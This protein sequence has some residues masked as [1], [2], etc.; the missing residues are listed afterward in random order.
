MTRV[1]CSWNRANR[2]FAHQK[3]SDSHKNQRANSQLCLFIFAD[4]DGLASGIRGTLTTWTLLL[5]ALAGRVIIA[6]VR[7]QTHLL[8]PVLLVND[9]LP[10]WALLGAHAGRAA[11]WHAIEAHT[12][13]HAIYCDTH[14]FRLAGLV[15]GW[16]ICALGSLASIQAD[17]ELLLL[18]RI[19]GP[20]RFGITLLSDYWAG[21]TVGKFPTMK[22][23]TL[24]AVATGGIFAT[25]WTFTLVH[26]VGELSQA[27][28]HTL[29]QAYVH[30]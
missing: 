30:R 6:I 27:R 22:A 19:I 1:I 9:T 5:T 26:A 13:G 21:F 18:Y 4:T 23:L 7:T 11:L 8:V 3:T 14:L 17:A 16:G 15:T 25:W 2:Y 24:D 28:A 12:L 20:V 10:L 29:R